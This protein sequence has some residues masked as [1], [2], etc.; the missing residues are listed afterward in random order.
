MVL[1]I[2]VTFVIKHYVMKVNRETAGKAP[3]ILDA[4]TRD[5]VGYFICRERLRKKGFSISPISRVTIF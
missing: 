1:I 2:K 5:R 4:G 3:H